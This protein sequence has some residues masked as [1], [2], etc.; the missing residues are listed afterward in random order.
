M[1]ERGTEIMGSYSDIFKEYERKGYIKKVE[2][3]ETERQ[4]FLPHFPVVR[5]EK[6][7]TKVRAVFD[8][9]MKCEGKSLNDA[10]Y[11]GPK[12][13]REIVDVLTRF[14]RA[15]VALMAD[16]SEMF[17]QVG[18]HEPARPY[19]RSIAFNVFGHVALVCVYQAFEFPLQVTLI[20]SL[21]REFL[22]LKAKPFQDDFRL[23]STEELR[24]ATRRTPGAF[25]V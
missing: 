18:L 8:T 10:I 12:L 16:I 14:R 17:L 24:I 22:R 13:Q 6:S 7:T 3:S 9:A 4:W 15:P 23:C 19:H 11:A 5:P 2:K 21:N 25:E 1:K 20:I